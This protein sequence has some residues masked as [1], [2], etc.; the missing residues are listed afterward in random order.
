MQNQPPQH[1]S[2]QQASSITNKNL[3][4]HENHATKAG[5]LLAIYHHRFCLISLDID[6]RLIS[7]ST[8]VLFGSEKAL[9]NPTN[10]DG[11]VVLHDELGVN[12]STHARKSKF[13]ARNSV[14]LHYFEKTW[15][16]WGKKTTALMNRFSSATT[17]LSSSTHSLRFK[18][19]WCKTENLN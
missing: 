19:R 4:R 3:A 7:I 11:K 15:N 2:H 5:L 13:E 8:V 12:T 9:K 16:I 6:S 10:T 17:G 18:R 1:E 14:P